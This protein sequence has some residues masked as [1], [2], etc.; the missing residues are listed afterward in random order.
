[1]RMMP[2]GGTTANPTA[3]VIHALLTF[4]GEPDYCA[5]AEAMAR[6]IDNIDLFQSHHALGGTP[7]SNCSRGEELGDGGVLC[8]HVWGIVRIVSAAQK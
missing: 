4:A 8:G 7:R 5:M 2:E 1:M 3:S 6:T